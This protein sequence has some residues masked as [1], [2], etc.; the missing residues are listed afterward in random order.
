MFGFEISADGQELV[1]LSKKYIALDDIIPHQIKYP[2]PLKVQNIAIHYAYDEGKEVEY[3]L[4]LTVQNWHHM[5]IMLT[6]DHQD[7]ILGHKVERLFER[8]PWTLQNYFKYKRGRTYSTFFAVPY[9][10]SEV[11]QQ[12]VMVYQVPFI[13]RKDAATYD[14]KYSPHAYTMYD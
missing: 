3:Y 7:E 11:S 8:F 12:M 13:V 9:V 5:E 1:Y 4:L 6:L 2:S 10:D 14:E